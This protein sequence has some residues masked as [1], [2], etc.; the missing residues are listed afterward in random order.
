MPRWRQRLDINVEV[1]VDHADL[2]WLGNVGVITPLVTRAAFDP[3]NTIA[4]I[5]GPGVMMRFVA[6]TLDRRGLAA[7]RIYISL[8]RNMRCAIAHCGHC[9]LG[10][11]FICKDGPVM[12]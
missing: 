6:A 8:E 4:L 5:C 1:T 7:D 12:S 11:H 3:G 2:R 10:A 9:Q